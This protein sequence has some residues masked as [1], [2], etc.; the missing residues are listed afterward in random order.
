MPWIS[1]IINVYKILHMQLQIENRSL[2]SQ[3]SKSARE[4]LGAW[5]VKINWNNYFLQQW[6]CYY[7]YLQYSQQDHFAGK[8][9]ACVNQLL[10]FRLMWNHNILVLQLIFALQV[11]KLWW[12]LLFADPNMKVCS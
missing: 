11:R 6:I 9:K 1:A 12:N 3:D 5:K 8:T 4:E 2:S 7:R 10:H